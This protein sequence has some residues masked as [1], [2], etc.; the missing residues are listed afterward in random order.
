MT[1]RN[2]IAF[3]SHFALQGEISG[4]LHFAQSRHSRNDKPLA[5]VIWRRDEAGLG[6]TL[7]TVMRGIQI[8]DWLGASPFVDTS[9]FWTSY[10]NATPN[11]L[12]PALDIWHQLFDPISE[13]TEDRLRA[14][15]FRVLLTD[16]R[17][18]V[19]EA[20]TALQ[21]YKRL[22]KRVRFKASTASYLSER[23]SSL[24]L[25]SST[26]GVHFRTGDMRIAPNHPTPPTFSQIAATVSNALD[27]MNFDQIFVSTQSRRDLEK[28]RARF[29][30]RVLAHPNL[31][32]DGSS[33][34]LSFPFADQLLPLA[35]DGI[36]G[37]QLAR[38]ALLDIYSL[39]VCGG[40][41]GGTSNMTLWAEVIK[42]GSFSF[43][44]FIWNGRNEN[45]K[46]ASAIR[47]HVR[48]RIPGG[49]GG[50]RRG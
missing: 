11:G 21:D 3:R 5:L 48:S 50:F 18:P 34:V 28:F 9:N 14:G 19:V 43:K 10:S 47:W 24:G 16:G 40:L 13:V 45:S 31:R 39:S 36:A 32:A 46:L 41:V 42:D 44:H 7:G 2:S 6:A 15:E 4:Q 1:A 23:A 33:Q 20:S 29:G 30:N 25:T 49:L 12:S 8:S 17:H 37:L 38:E 22:W 26:L 27:T 35:S